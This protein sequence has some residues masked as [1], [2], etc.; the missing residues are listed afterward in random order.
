MRHRL[1]SAHELLFASL[2]SIA[3]CVGACT[4]STVGTD[5]GIVEPGCRA[6]SACYKTG[7]D[8]KCNRSDVEGDCKVCDPN[9][10]DCICDPGGDRDLGTPGARCLSAAAICVGRSPMTCAGVG[11]R[12]LPVGMACSTPMSGAPPQLIA[13]S[14]GAALESHCTY[15]DDVCCPGTVVD[16]GATD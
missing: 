6:P 1:T 8:C 12:C 4:S 10:K 2:L 11:A 3:A 9:V 5:L 16:L 14:S 13:A 15:L 7:A